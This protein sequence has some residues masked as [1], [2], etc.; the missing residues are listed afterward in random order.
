M[1]DYEKLFSDK[2]PVNITLLNFLKSNNER[3]QKY[4]Q[5]LIKI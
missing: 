5:I 1:K 4:F 2:N 3:L